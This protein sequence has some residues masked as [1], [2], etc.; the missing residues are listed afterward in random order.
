MLLDHLMDNKKAILSGW[1]EML[2]LLKT[3]WVYSGDS[4][5]YEPALTAEHLKKIFFV[6]EF[7][8]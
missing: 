2:N 7:L 6:Y 4:G 3:M 1:S 5:G 8:Q